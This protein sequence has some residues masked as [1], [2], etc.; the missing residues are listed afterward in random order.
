MA[1]QQAPASPIDQIGDGTYG[2]PQLRLC[3]VSKSLRV[4]D[5]SQV[6]R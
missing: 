5:A 2:S 1:G 4:N 6:F 3:L